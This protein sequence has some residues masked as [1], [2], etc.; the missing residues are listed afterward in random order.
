MQTPSPDPWWPTEWETRNGVR[1]ARMTIPRDNVCYDVS[2]F[3]DGTVL[4]H[5][6]RLDGRMQ[7]SH[8]AA[9]LT[10]KT[11]DLLAARC[12]LMDRHGSAFE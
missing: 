9:H 5:A 6:W 3:G 8:E 11:D 12:L 7:V 4:T 10:F 2:V 1:W